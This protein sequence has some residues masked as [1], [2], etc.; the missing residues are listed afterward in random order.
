MASI[1]TGHKY[2][3]T[4]RTPLHVCVH[5]CFCADTHTHVCVCVRMDSFGNL[6]A[7]IKAPQMSF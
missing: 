1:H 3:S 7:I 6:A 4:G 5:I 2:S